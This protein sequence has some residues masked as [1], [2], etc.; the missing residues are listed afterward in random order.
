MIIPELR[1]ICQ[2][3]N[4]FKQ[5]AVRAVLI[6]KANALSVGSAFVTGYSYHHDIDPEDSSVTAT[7]NTLIIKR[8]FT[9]YIYDGFELV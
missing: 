8:F 9:N 4:S 5:S 6:A 1:P 2:V 7:Q 3:L